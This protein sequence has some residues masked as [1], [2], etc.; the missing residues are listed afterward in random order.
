MVYKIVKLGDVE[1]EVREPRT[2]DEYI[3]LVKVQAKVWG[4]NSLE[5]AVPHHLLISAHRNGGVVLGAFLKDSGEAVGIV[6]GIPAYRNGKLYHYSHMTGVIPEH[7]FRGLGYI[8]KLA[9]RE[10]VLKQGMDLIVWTYDPLQ[11]ANAKFNIEKLGAIARKFYENYYGELRDEINR[12]MPTDR[13]E[14]EWWIKSRRVEM[15][16]RG[17]LKTPSPKELIELGAELVT[18]TEVVEGVR[19]FKG[20]V[21][22]SAETVLVEIPGD[23]NSLRRWRDVLMGWRLGCREVFEEYLNR[24]GYIVVGFTSEVRGGERRNFYVLWRTSLEK[25]L[26][27]CVPWR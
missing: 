17:E 6:F 11:G 25:V 4:M 2:V 9:Q 12:G 26:E 20:F 19:V 27:G 22:T 8:L 14:A 10:I 5:D 18:E 1:V 3:E 7:R 21:K 24:R 13:F 16:L 15:K 23:L